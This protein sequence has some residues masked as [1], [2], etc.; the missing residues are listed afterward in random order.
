M[1]G[2]RHVVHCDRVLANNTPKSVF[3]SRKGG[4]GRVQI[5]VASLKSI[6]LAEGTSVLRHRQEQEL[7]LGHKFDAKQ[8][9]YLVLVPFCSGKRLFALLVLSFCGVSTEV[10]PI[11]DGRLP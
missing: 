6:S 3:E 1:S 4:K 8:L 10:F 7:G 5:L 2:G 11:E 9:D